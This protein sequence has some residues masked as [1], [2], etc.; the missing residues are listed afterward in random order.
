MKL[1]R[2]AV[3]AAA[4]VA[5]AAFAGVFQPAGARGQAAE[6]Q[7]GGLT[8]TGSGSV[9]ATPDRAHFTFGTVAQAR[10]AAAALAASSQTVD[11]V[12]DALRRAG[13][14]RADIQ[15]SEVSLFPRMSESGQEIVGYTATNSVSAVVRRIAQLGAV[16]DAAVGAGANQIY[17]PSLLASD[18]D[19][20]Y[21][22]ALKAAVAEARTKAETL[23]AAAG[24]SLGQ[25]T[26]IVESGASPPQ[27]MPATGE[28]AADTQIEPGTQKIEAS[29]SV[30]FAFG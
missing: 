21:R 30:T 22:N 16:I 9:N 11:R 13:V 3:L 20:G 8:V 17:G 6:T 2:I 26:A 10:T 4:G 27:P 1:A 23:A 7:T 24:K 5:I 14:A 29:V 15:T 12:V 19:A 25:I 18:Q 28:R